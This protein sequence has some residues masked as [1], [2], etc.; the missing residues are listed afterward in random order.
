MALYQE[1]YFWMI[2][3]GVILVIATVVALSFLGESNYWFWVLFSIGTTI[4]SIGV[5]WYL[6]SDSRKKRETFEKQALTNAV[7][8]AKNIGIAQ[9]TGAPYNP[10]IIFASVSDPY[11]G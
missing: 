8:Q 1:A 6:I 7:I 2:L 10:N 11:S 3:L 5:Y 4:L 9:A